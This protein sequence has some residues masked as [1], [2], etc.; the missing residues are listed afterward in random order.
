[1]GL[2]EQFIEI[3][4]REIKRDGAQKM[5]EYLENSDFFTAPASTKF[6]LS[7]EGGLCEHSINVYYRLKQLVENEQS[8]WAK[9][10][11]G[12][13]IAIIALL[14][15]VCKIG[16]YAVDYRNQKQPDGSWQKVPYY[17]IDELLPY[18][19]GEKSVYI[20]NGYM[21]LTREE[22]ICINWHMGGY[23]ERVR[24]G[25]Y[26]IAKA[27]EKFPLAVLTHVADALASYLD[28]ERQ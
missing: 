19:H 5:L 26:S 4:Q 20:I 27:Y 8:D 18:G 2:K 12:E 6:H 25:S 1:M 24:G 9:N 3:Y 21:R 13:S 10:V 16:M 7:R 23:D 15:D 14:H 11:S 17:V 28:E 22:A